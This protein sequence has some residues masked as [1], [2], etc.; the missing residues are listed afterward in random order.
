MKPQFASVNRIGYASTPANTTTST[1]ATSVAPVTVKIPTSGDP[2][3]ITPDLLAATGIKSV[4]ETPEAATRPTDSGPFLEVVHWAP[5]PDGITVQYVD[6]VAETKRTKSLE[7]E[8]CVWFGQNMPTVLDELKPERDRVNWP[9]P[10]QAIHP[11][12]TRMFILPEHWFNFFYE[13][14]G[15]TGPYL[16]GAGFITFLLSKELFVIDHDYPVGVSLIIIFYVFTKMYGKTMS[17][18]L[19]SAIWVR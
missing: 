8:Y 4:M 19:E 16:F 6:T 14:T 1:P 9:R 18:Q 2:K 3:D 12:P 5:T 11:P 15:V 7:D 13:K 10:V 17:Q